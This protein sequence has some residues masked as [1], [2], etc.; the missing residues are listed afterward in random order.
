VV[1]PRALSA[2]ALEEGLV[3]EIR[4]GRWTAA[5]TRRSLPRGRS[6]RPA[7]CTAR[8]STAIVTGAAKASMRRAVN[9]HSSEPLSTSPRY[10]PWKTG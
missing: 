2:G 5:A 4:L 7:P 8:P 10:P 3:L 1:G 6:R 9:R